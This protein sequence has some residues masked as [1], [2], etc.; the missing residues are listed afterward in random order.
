MSRIDEKIGKYKGKLEICMNYVSGKWACMASKIPDL[1]REAEALE[2][3]IADLIEIN[4]ELESLDN[5]ISDM[6][7]AAS[8]GMKYEELDIKFK[9]VCG[10]SAEEVREE[11]IKYGLPG[12]DSKITEQQALDQLAKSYS[13]SSSD[14]GQ[15]ISM[16]TAN[17]V[18][19]V[20]LQS[21]RTNNIHELHEK[22]D[23]YD[24]LVGAAINTNTSVTEMEAGIR[25]M[26]SSGVNL[27]EWKK[28]QEQNRPNKLLP[29]FLE[30]MNEYKDAGGFLAFLSDWYYDEYSDGDL[31]SDF[32]VDYIE[33][34]IETLMIAWLSD[35][36]EL[37]KPAE[38]P[39]YVADW[40]KE[41]KDEH[42][43]PF[44]S[45]LAAYQ[46]GDKVQ[47]WLYGN[48]STEQDIINQEKYMS[49]WLTGN[50]TVKPKTKYMVVFVDSE[51]DRQILFKKGEEYE[52][53]FESNNEGYW[54]QYFTEEEIRAFDERSMTFAE[55]LEA[56]KCSDS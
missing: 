40:L 37:S 49:A 32:A 35:A 39:Q 18:S 29:L 46:R 20:D 30:K 53:D 52:V 56:E 10:K 19:V 17:N 27:S 15:V 33:K 34:N 28:L 23:K 3:V 25:K 55:A 42:R 48:K 6:S 7:A 21:L 38:V 1:K 8:L 4:E 47:V 41:F 51:S 26:V 12:N 45:M 16:L 22:A 9:H 2:A 36:V 11:I 24:S 54:E 43:A 50:Y 14:L 13:Y 5:E 31:E 44:E